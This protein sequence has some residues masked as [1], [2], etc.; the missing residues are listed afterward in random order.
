MCNRAVGGILSKPVLLCHSLLEPPPNPDGSFGRGGS[1]PKGSSWIF[2]G[3]NFAF[4]HLCGV[5]T[6]GGVPASI[7]GKFLQDP[8]AVG[9]FLTGDR[10]KLHQRLEDMGISLHKDRDKVNHRGT[11]YVYHR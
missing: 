5:V 2:V 10:V 8:T 11:R 9:A 1:G 4:Q 7:V 6:L 3:D